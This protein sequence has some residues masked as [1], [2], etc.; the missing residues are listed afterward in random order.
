VNSNSGIIKLVERKGD[1]AQSAPKRH[2]A[3]R[4]AADVLSL[5]NVDQAI[6][7]LFGEAVQRLTL[8]AYEQDG[9]GFC[10][11]D[12]ITGRLLLPAPWGRLGHKRWG[13]TPSESVVLREM[14]L[15]RQ[16]GRGGRSPGLWRYDQS[17]RTWRL[18]LYDFDTLADG[19]KYWERFPL[20]VAEYRDARSK[21]LGT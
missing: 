4:K 11:I 8:L 10:N 20:T 15:Q 9:S 13:I 16:I 18:N 5:R 21:R 19:Q 1:I 17:Q 2:T 14:I 7:E 3:L 12:P 6:V